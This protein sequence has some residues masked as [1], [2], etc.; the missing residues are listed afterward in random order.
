M[1]K[2]HTSEASGARK[3]SDGLD[4]YFPQIAD[5]SLR[6]VSMLA[7]GNK[8]LSQTAHQVWEKELE[9][10]RPDRIEFPK[11]ASSASFRGILNQWHDGAEL[12][13]NNM[14]AIQDTM[15]DCGWKLLALAAENMTESERQANE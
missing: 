2:N 9:L 3:A 11:D 5:L 13:I 8:I 12:A 7:E 10:F 15:R 4:R 14:R 1:A 6:S